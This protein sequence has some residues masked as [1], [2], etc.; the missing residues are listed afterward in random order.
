VFYLWKYTSFH[1]NVTHNIQPLQEY[2]IFI[3]VIYLIILFRMVNLEILGKM[4]GHFAN[5]TFPSASALD[6]LV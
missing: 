5:F 3:A 1:V 6:F 2:Y 4:E